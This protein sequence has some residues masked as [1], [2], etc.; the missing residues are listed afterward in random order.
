[1]A[2]FRRTAW[3]YYNRRRRVPEPA[4]T[5]AEAGLVAVPSHHPS[6]DLTLR[7][8][9]FRDGATWSYYNRPRRIGALTI[10]AVALLPIAVPKTHPS[11]NQALRD[12]T[13]RLTGYHW[14]QRRRVVP[15]SGASATVTVDTIEEALYYKL[16]TDAAITA[17]I[18]TRVYPFQMP[19]NPTYPAMTYR[20]IS[21]R[22]P[23]DLS[24]PG[25]MDNPRFQFDCY[26]PSYAAAKGL[27]KAL[28]SVMVGF[29][30][31]VLGVDICAVFF[32]NEVDRFDD[33]PGVFGIAVDL[34]VQH[35]L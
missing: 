24:G 16:S 17:L 18:S 23:F 19:Q 1:M 5:P 6:R 11:R 33:V 26:A 31:V 2:V 13:F 28:R 22:Q 20:R 8:G 14:Y 10:L 35:K 12:E 32:L 4:A 15:G 7:D 30:G 9:T 29:S 27:A 3:Q 21:T 34:R 25:D